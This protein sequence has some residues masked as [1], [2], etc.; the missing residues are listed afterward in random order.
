MTK[1][2][3]YEDLIF[4]WLKNGSD[5]DM[6]TTAKAWSWQC[7]QGRAAEIMRV[8]IYITD[9]A[10][11]YGEFGGLGSALTNGIKVQL[12]DSGGTELF[13][14][15]D[16]QTIKTNEQWAALS[17][18]DASAIIELGAGDDYQPIR[19]T[20]GKAFSGEA[21]AMGSLQ[22]FVITTQDNLSN[23][24]AMRAMIQGRYL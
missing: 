5:V 20:I 11:G 16:G 18:V 23:L 2:P 14:F 7:A 19:W 21:L 3:E 12:K 24:S 15:L 17:G 4:S 6:A 10:M 1:N 13:D 22:Q 8:N 9:A